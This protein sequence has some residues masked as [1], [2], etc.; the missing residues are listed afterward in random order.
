MRDLMMRFA[1]LGRNCE[2]GA[3]QQH[4]QAVPADLLRWSATPI[5]ALLHM[6]DDSF[7]HLTE[8]VEVTRA[9]ADFHVHSAHYGFM[10]HDWT[11]DT[12]V[13][14]EK[15]AERQAIALPRLARK[16]M[17]EMRDASRIFAITLRPGHDSEALAIR[18]HDAMNRFGNPVLLYVTEG[19]PVSVTE[20]RPRLLAG[21]IPAFADPG[22]V[23]S[24]VNT[25]DWLALCQEAAAHVDAHWT[26][27]HP[28][29]GL[30]D[31]C[32]WRQSVTET[33]RDDVDPVVH[34]KFRISRSD[35]IVTAGSCFAQHLGRHLHEAGF[36]HLVAERLHPAFSQASAARYGYGMFSARY[37]NIY[38]SRQLLQTLQRAHGLFKPKEDAWMRPDGRVI[39]PF[40]PRIQPDGFVGIDEYERDREQHF[41]AIRRAVRDMSVFV[42]TLGLTECWASRDDGAV[43]PLCPGVAGGRFDPDRHVFVNL[44][45]AE[46]VADMN[47][48][49]ALIRRR[50]PAA[51]VLL[52]VSPVALV[53]TAED[54]SVLTA[55]TYAKAVL[56]AAAEEIAADKDHV[57]YFP[58]YEVI[59]GNHARGHYLQKD[60]RE[61]RP[62][63]VAHVMRLFMRHYA[64][65]TPSDPAP[66]HAAAIADEAPMV[67]ERVAR[68][69]CDEV[70]LA[71]DRPAPN[72]A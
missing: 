67:G 58:S 60:L 34:A 11:R 63:G 22:H 18:L 70:A 65:A 68:V 44:R 64:D 7:A 10:W 23:P 38:T 19:A 36:N 9:G 46:V 30:P 17:D 24:T 37:G 50:N 3:A 25:A 41:R 45:V 4:F 1:S 61:V 66:T 71:R 39:D 5:E 15:I 51:R 47:Q 33:P 62:A 59:L 49:I 57:A 28:Y 43:F 14:P 69:L 56:R 6:L 35:A 2:I 42:F 26:T 29:H 32:F 13:T 31:H 40:R 12:S 72:P 27:P 54:Q 55:T 52:T 21:T 20:I 8:G 53:A 48:A 16:L